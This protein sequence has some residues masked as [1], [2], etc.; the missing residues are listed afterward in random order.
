MSFQARILR[1]YQH[2]IT[3]RHVSVCGGIALEETICQR[4]NKCQL[5]RLDNAFCPV[6]IRKW[7]E[8]DHADYAG[9]NHH[10][11][12]HSSS[13]NTHKLVARG[14]VLEELAQRHEQP[15]DD[16]GQRKDNADSG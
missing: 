10:R 14:K 11:A 15:A 16:G 13:A 2:I 5:R 4:V 8:S 9:Q 3:R 12:E 7:N 6:A 1:H